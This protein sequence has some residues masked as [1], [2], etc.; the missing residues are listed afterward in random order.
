M[1]DKKT[2]QETS[3]RWSWKG[4]DLG[5]LLQRNKDTIKVL[6]MFIF[7]YSYFEGFQFKVFLI[8]LLAIAGKMAVDSID[9]FLTEVKLE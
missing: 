9:F 6:S 3:P 8:G 2:G 1:A 5:V 7:G 4:Y